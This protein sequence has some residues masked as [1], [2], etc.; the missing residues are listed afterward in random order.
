MDT[1]LELFTAANNLT[2]LAIIGLLVGVVLILVQSMK[3]V[4]V[5]RD[6]HLKHV[7]QKLGAMIE[8][9]HRIEVGIAKLSGKFD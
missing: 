9:L 6:N 8:V 3:K 4:D 2:P 7:D 1:I 5:I